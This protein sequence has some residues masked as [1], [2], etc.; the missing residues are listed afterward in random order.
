MECVKDK[1]E[2]RSLT[3]HEIWERLIDFYS[4][5]DE[6]TQEEIKNAHWYLN[7]ALLIIDNKFLRN[8]VLDNHP[9]SLCF[10]LSQAAAFA[11]DCL[12][13]ID[14]GR[15]YQK[16][17]LI[18]LNGCPQIINGRRVSFPQE[19]ADSQISASLA[20]VIGGRTDDTLKD[21]P[22]LLERTIQIAKDNHDEKTSKKASAFLSFVTQ[23]LADNKN[24]QN[25]LGGQRMFLEQ[26]ANHLKGYPVGKVNVESNS[27]KLHT[28]NPKFPYSLESIPL[29]GGEGNGEDKK[30]LTLVEVFTKMACEDFGLKFEDSELK[31]LIFVE[32]TSCIKIEFTW[33]DKK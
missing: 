14:Q 7:S 20:R 23:K 27:I 12:S 10:L 6:P 8:R 17:L 25:Q 21:V 26:I 11:Y 3:P 22:K 33:V 30:L 13:L 4:M 5:E 32:S 31:P 15:C 29:Y 1:K 19:L 18:W 24:A 9:N 16:A 2:L 28:N